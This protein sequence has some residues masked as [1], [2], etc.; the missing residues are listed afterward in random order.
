MTG[1]FVFRQSGTSWCDRVIDP[2]GIDPPNAASAAYDR[3]LDRAFAAVLHQ[4]PRIETER[5]RLAEALAHPEVLDAA[6]SAEPP[7][8]ALRGWPLVVALLH[9]SFELRYRD[10][11]EMTLFAAAACHAARHLDEAVYGAAFIADLQARAAAELANAYRVRERYRE[12]GRAFEEADRHRRRGTGDLL[13]AARLSDLRASLAADERRF[14]DALGDLAMARDLYERLGDRH[15]AGRAVAMMGFYTHYGGDSRR[16]LELARA[17]LAALDAGRDPRLV[18]TTR[19]AVLDIALELGEVRAAAELLFA[20]GLR[21][22]F[23]DDPLNLLKLRWVEGK[24]FAGLGRLERAEQAFREARAGFAERDLPLR[25]ALAGLDLLAVHLRR[26][27]LAEVVELAAETLA[28]FERLDLGREALRA[29][30]CLEAACREGLVTL[31]VV[32]HVAGFLSRYERD[33]SLVFAW[34]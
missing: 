7:H 10:P 26:R 11:V 1:A 29:A 24:V 13:L 28:V 22:A 34:P 30:E 14:A 19:L 17:G 8:G 12:A 33:P 9:R 27:R 16:G 23:A 6:L 21:Q 25:A 2:S 3:A 31:A 15:L 4:A 32:H 18:A 20:A 5:Q